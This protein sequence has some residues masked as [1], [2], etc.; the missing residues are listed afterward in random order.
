M[1][2]SMFRYDLSRFKSIIIWRNEW[3]RTTLQL[4]WYV[5]ELLTQ[6]HISPVWPPS[7]I[8]QIW[9][10]GIS[11]LGKFIISTSKPLFSPS[12]SLVLDISSY[13]WTLEFSILGQFIVQT[14]ILFCTV[15]VL[16]LLD[17]R[18]SLLRDGHVLD[19]L[20]YIVRREIET[21]LVVVI[22][23]LRKWSEFWPLDIFTQFWFLSWFTP[24]R[25]LNFVT[26][27]MLFL[28]SHKCELVPML[29]NFLIWRYF[30]FSILPIFLF[31]ID[32]FILFEQTGRGS[33]LELWI[34]ML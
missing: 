12:R 1:F 29:E 28:T 21:S 5:I 14:L 20:R 15:R 26:K 4:N 10:F 7:H 19:L 22:P 3:R 16:S 6:T 25:N 18:I 8:L 2:H 9:D 27:S 30:R 33:N 31:L 34:I 24:L 13:C 23:K 32:Q 11:A 17:E